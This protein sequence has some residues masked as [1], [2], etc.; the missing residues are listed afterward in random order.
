MTGRGNAAALFFVPSAR[1]SDL[2]RIFICVF[3][4]VAAFAGGSAAAQDNPI[5]ARLAAFTEAYNAGDAVVVSGF[6]TENGALLPPQ[7]KALVGRPPIAA[8]YAAA[9]AN[10]VGSLKYRVVEIEQVGPDTAVEIGE[11]QVAL[12]TQTVTGRSMHIWKRVNGGWFLHRDIYHV[13]AVSK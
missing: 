13:L 2:V 8:H 9:F 1:E 11:T 4:L 12:K 3:V 6:Y 5:L 7:G 10:G